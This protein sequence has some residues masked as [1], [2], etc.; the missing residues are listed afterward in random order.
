[1]TP[2]KPY[3]R[4]D[5]LQPITEMYIN[6]RYDDMIKQQEQ[7]I[8]LLK[9]TKDNKY[10]VIQSLREEIIKYVNESEKYIAE[11][12]LANFGLLNRYDMLKDFYDEQV[13]L[14]KMHLRSFRKQ[15]CIDCQ[16]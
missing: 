13:E 10:P 14:F 11:M 1:M 9:L 4:Y 3:L 2:R 15:K 7:L 16:K 12:E 8:T 6:D 5:N